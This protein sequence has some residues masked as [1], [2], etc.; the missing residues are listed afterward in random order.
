MMLTMY[1]NCVQVTNINLWAHVYG[2]FQWRAIFFNFVQ[3]FLE[4]VVPTKLVFQ[5]GC[6]NY[7]AH[8]FYLNCVQ[9]TIINL[10]AHVWYD[11]MA[12]HLF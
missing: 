5:R 11:S 1:L 6:C 12:R 4:R 2:T 9:A 8:A 3:F 7:D 10:W